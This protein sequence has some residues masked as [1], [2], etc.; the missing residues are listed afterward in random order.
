MVYK[1]FRL[2]VVV[3]IAVIFV[4]AILLAFVLSQTNWFFTPLVIILLLLI[5]LL[6]LIR[7]VE[8]TNRDITYFLLSIQQ[9]G[10][11]NTFKS[12]KRG[13][14]YDALSEAFNSIIKEFQRV[15]LEKESHYQ[16]LQTLNE[17][18]GVAIISYLD[19]GEIQLYNYA[20][21]KLIQKPF[22]NNIHDLKDINE[23]LYELI[24]D[25]KPGRRKI[26][27]I[28]LREQTQ[29]L[30]IHFKEFKLKDQDFK[31]VLMQNINAE[32]DEKEVEAWQ[33]LTSVLTHEIMNS[34]TPIASLTEAIN[35][36]LNGGNEHKKSVAKLEEE[37]L[38][39]IHT[40]LETIENRSKGLLKFV[41]AYKDFSKTP[42]INLVRTDIVALLRR[43]Q[44][45]LG[46][47]FQQNKIELDWPSD[48]KAVII[49]ADPELIEQVLINLLK[50]AMEALNG[51]PD[52]KIKIR[53]SDVNNHR[54]KLYISDNGMGI[55]KNILD[56]IFVPF[57][58]T[59]KKGT[60]VGLSLSKKIMK[61][62][63]GSIAVQS[64][65]G[66][67]TTFILDFPVEQEV[68]SIDRET[69]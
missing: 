3:R 24:M 43:I 68:S 36:M 56:K 66:K 30:S 27:K 8:K 46:P 51:E 2:N 55:D 12:N 11:T 69:T 67:G 10:F 59:K 41:H 45:L 6:S 19:S 23:E 50:N 29:Q 61:L 31:L 38:E 44:S 7:Y 17:N 47:D 52:G 16:Y 9:G 13:I 37:D 33:K 32:L 39:D 25:L 60:G 48:H 18:I 62:H 54:L 22:L 57:F 63:D 14:N 58:T 4:L 1:N 20:A 49:L 5:F 42:D 35:K 28:F 64:K 65:K 40:S 26:A 15:A 21:K 53:L 34:V